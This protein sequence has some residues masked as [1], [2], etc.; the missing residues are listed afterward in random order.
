[1]GDDYAAAGCASDTGRRPDCHQDGPEREAGLQLLTDLREAA[2]G[3]QV[4]TR[5]LVP[6]LDMY[7]A[8]EHARL[9]D[10][11]GAIDRC[12]AVID[13]LPAIGEVDLERAG[14]GCPRGGLLAPW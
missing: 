9:G 10:I 1:M 8:K 13:G 11:D 3:E 12:R 2:E 7:M 4:P 5:G 6:L 14:H